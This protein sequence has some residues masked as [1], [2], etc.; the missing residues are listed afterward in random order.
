MNDS[1]EIGPNTFSNKDETV[2]NHKGHNYY[3][4]CGEVVRSYPDGSE[5]SCTRPVG[6]VSPDHED[7]LGNL[8]YKAGP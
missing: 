6:H 2:I 1:I 3:K 5:S 4:A 8:L 7:H